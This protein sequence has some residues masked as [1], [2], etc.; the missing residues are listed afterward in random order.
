PAEGWQRKNITAFLSEDNGKTWEGGLLLDERTGVAYPDGFQSKDGSIFI[1]YDYDRDEK[2]HIYLSRFT[3]EDILAG[4]VKSK[5][6]FLRKLIVEARPELVERKYR[7]LY[8]GER[9]YRTW[10]VKNSEQ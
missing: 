7:L 10:V 1:S 6:S 5:N 8:D 9:S 3:E 2:G 4:T